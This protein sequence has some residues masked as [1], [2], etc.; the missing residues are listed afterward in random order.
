MKLPEVFKTEQYTETDEIGYS[1]TLAPKLADYQAVIEYDQS[2]NATVTI[3]NGNNVIL[4]FSLDDG[5]IFEIN[6]EVIS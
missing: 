6:R 5:T 4:D 1:V 2:G 3:K